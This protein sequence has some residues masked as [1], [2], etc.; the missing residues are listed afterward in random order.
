MGFSATSRDGQGW[1]PLSYAVLE[2]R[3]DLV[4]ALLDAGANATG[5][6]KR[7]EPAFLCVKGMSNLHLAAMRCDEDDST[8]VESIISTPRARGADAA[9]KDTSGNSCLHFACTLGRIACIEAP[10]S[11]IFLPSRTRR[12]RSG[13]LRSATSH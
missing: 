11:S 5:A 1:S 13:L 12:W 2:G 4:T 9:Q 8:T 6:L 7:D 10:I 3:T